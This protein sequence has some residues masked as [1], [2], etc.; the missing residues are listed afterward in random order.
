MLMAILFLALAAAFCFL[1]TLRLCHMFQLEGYKAPGYMRWL[2]EHGLKGYGWV[3]ACAA[4][5][6]AAFM[7]ACSVQ[8]W[9]QYV[10]FAAGFLGFGF[11]G[12]KYVRSITVKDAKKP[13]AYTA[14]VK[15]LLATEAVLLA[16]FA[17]GS[18]FSGR[19]IGAIFVLLAPFHILLANWINTPMENA[20]KKHYFN[21]AKR[22]LAER[23][24]LIK[25]GITGSFGKTSTKF[26]LGTLLSE[27][28]HTLV[29]P[30][31]YNT[32]MGLTR[33]IREQLK[34]EHQ[35][36][37]AEMGA[38]HVG[39]IAEL[40]ELVKPKYG[41]V[42]SVGPQHM[43]TFKTLENIISTKYELIAGLPADGAAFFPND[44]GITKGMYDRTEKKKWLYALADEQ[45][46][47]DIAAK[48]ILPGED[49]S[50]FTIVYDHGQREFRAKT[51]LLGKHNIQN[52][53][54]CVAVALELGLSEEELI[55]G[56]AKVEP[57]EHRL[58]LL[59]TGNGVTVI[60]DA[61]NANPAGTR[62]AME[63][64]RG[65]SGRKIV[66]TPGMVEL[67]EIEEQENRA[68]GR[69]M[70]HAADLVYL[71][72][73]RHTRPI[74]EGLLE[75]G[76]PEEQIEVCASLGE[77][78]EKMGRILRA[79]DVVLFENDLPDNYNE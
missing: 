50:E 57:V 6:I 41:I 18:Y 71:V 73:P 48:D 59:P 39:D 66:V 70:A 47:W 55:R 60:D 28:Y 2:G 22:K 79:G 52:I 30:S 40:V 19:T 12:G 1:A 38:K 15:R 54:G 46:E 14:R 27:K 26:I 11:C 32:P 69:D 78:S 72:G 8:G 74:Y 45:D 77:A 7:G 68:F 53:L 67:G 76:F 4:L 65:F 5:F 23:D 29:P 61:F 49:G 35:V 44:G 21:D 20:V 3:L 62:V 36:F 33:V 31:S 43:E 13:L 34:P 10:I 24:D 51:K 16:L 42:T 64:L 56:I 58:Q 17:A 75:E 63:V 25:V 9:L 37:L